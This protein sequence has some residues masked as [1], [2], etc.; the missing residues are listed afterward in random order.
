MPMSGHRKADGVKDA[1]LASSEFLGHGMALAASVALFGW[2]GWEIGERVGSP[3]LLML[4]GVLVGGA[5][6]FYHLYGRLTARL[7]QERDC[8]ESEAE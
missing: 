1:L 8:E 5:A 2:I 6:G 7:G 4:V 3:S